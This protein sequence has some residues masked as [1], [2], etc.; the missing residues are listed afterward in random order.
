LTMPIHI[1][2]P[3]CGKM[4]K[5]RDELRGHKIACIACKEVIFIPSKRR[6]DDDE[7]V[8][9]RRKLSIP[10][11]RKRDF[12]RDRDD[13]D[14]ADSPL[15]RRKIRK[16]KKG[17][18]VGLILGLS[19]GGIGLVAGIV[20]LVLVLNKPGDSKEGA[21][22]LDPVAEIKKGDPEFKPR[23][24]IP[25]PD[26]DAGKPLPAQMALQV[27][28]RVKQATVYLRVTSLGGQVAEGS[29]FFAV[30]PGVVF[31]NAHVLGML[32]ATS[33]PPKQVEVVVHS[34]EANEMRLTGQVLG[35][36]RASDLAVVRVE[37]NLPA[38][39][40]LELDRKLVETQKVYIFGFPF[41]A[42]L[43]KN[44]TVSESSISSLRKDATGALEQIQVNGG[45]HPGNSGGPVVNSLGRVVGVSVSGIRGT[46]IN[47]AIPAEFVKLNLEGRF[48]DSKP[49]EPFVRG[50]QAH[51]PVYFTCL[52]ALG[53]VRQAQVEVWT[54]QPGRLRP[55]SLSKP[56]AMPGDGKRQTHALAYQNGIAQGDVP[57][58]KIVPGQV[59]WLQPVI[60]SSSGTIQWGTAQ[61]FNPSLALE[62]APADLTAKLS[63]F[64][65]RSVHLISSQTS[66]LIKGKNKAVDADKTEVH[67]LEVIE[68]DA[69]GARV[70]VGFAKPKLASEE[71]GRN[72]PISPDVATLVGHLPPAFIV[73]NTN[74][75]RQRTDTHLNPKLRVSPLVRAQ[76]EGFYN[77]IC[78]SYEA[79]NLI[80]PNRTV[81][82]LQ[83]WQTMIPMLLKTGKK[84]QV[85]DL[86]LTCTYE[87]SHWVGK[88]KDATITVTGRVQ[89]RNNFRKMVDGKVAGKFVFNLQGFI[90]AARLTITSEATLLA[91]LQVIGEFTIEL[92]RTPGNP[93]NITLP[94]RPSPPTPKGDLVAQ[95][96]A[97]LG[98]TD[99]L[100]TEFGNRGARMKTYSVKLEAGTKYGI[101]LN[102]NAF[103]AYLRLYNPNGA[104]LA[105]DDD[106]GGN[107]N[108]R[109]DYQA[110]VSGNYRIEATAF[111]GKQGPFQLTVLKLAKSTI[112]KT[113]VGNPEKFVK[114]P[115]GSK[116]VSYFKMES[117]KGDYIGQGKSYAYPGDSLR[118]R[119]DARGVQVFI[120]IPK[121]INGRI[122]NSQEWMIMFGGPGKQFLEVG[123]YQRARR[124]AFSGDLPG[125]DV[126]GQGRG[127]NQ[128][129]GAFV[130]WELEV[131]G[132]EIVRMA[133]DFVQRG[134][135]QNAPPLKGKLR[136]NSKFE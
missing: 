118:I 70:R 115:A 109:I 111:D 52:D 36:D 90:A 79:V 28:H 114:P 66:T 59:V 2:C 48:L 7:T 112:A 12:R 26:P 34:G 43:G 89:G 40:P 49:A 72:L 53:R 96:N 33:R 122:I 31:T 83:S 62:R 55:F 68:P 130:V 21:K 102:S 29:G 129:F 98:P 124:C 42:Q 82:A 119:K 30:E 132:D 113:P 61:S 15:P 69:F 22:K 99:P 63:A 60:V 75:L 135:F 35:V 11:G 16:E 87:G 23:P 64:K 88:D 13:D 19:A 20:A 4:M 91:D 17:A 45:M 6:N 41:G 85:V 103:D 47:F 73:D 38:A 94:L 127:N 54:G 71:D 126:F 32:Q 5:I 74:K 81:Q 108:A 104:L 77:Q 117:S 58:P 131:Q 134:E 93:L 1:V 123:E 50:G 56:V 95:H 133:I 105:K 136:W 128:V 46:Q 106:S 27:V 39:L 110:T 8:Q 92:V 25:K 65:E 3:V 78:N 97:N 67:L 9:E 24:E 37:G 10:A 101:L 120:Q 116:P 76:V 80:M 84:S 100:D 44:I 86:V 18:G 14:F 57:L 51:V 107:L 125:I 121:E